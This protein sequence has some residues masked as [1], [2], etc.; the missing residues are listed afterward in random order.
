MKRN[1]SPLTVSVRRDRNYFSVINS[2]HYKDWITALLSLYFSITVV[3][4]YG[5]LEL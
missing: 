3:L 1:K 4:N 2:S 5:R